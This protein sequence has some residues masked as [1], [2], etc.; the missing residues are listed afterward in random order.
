MKDSFTNMREGGA[1]VVSGISLSERASIEAAVGEILASSPF[2]TTLQCQKLLQYVVTHTLAGEDD[3][4]RERV[5]GHEVF[6]RPAAYEPGED[7]VVRIRA[8]DVRKR[9]AIYYQ[10]L[11]TPPA[12]RIDIPSGS[13]RAVFTFTDPLQPK[14]LTVETSVSETA[15]DAEAAKAETVSATTLSA[16]NAEPS[17]LS[18]AGA[19]LAPE[20]MTAPQP[21]VLAQILPSGS[22]IPWLRFGLGASC[23]LL[24]AVAFAVYILAP[25]RDQRAIVAMWGPF[26]A[27]KTPVLLSIGSNAVYRVSEPVSDAYSEAHNLQGSGMEFFPDF[28]PQQTL[29]STGLQPSFASF[30]AEGDVSAVAEVVA[31]LTGLHQKTQERFPNNISFAEV[32]TNPTVLIGGFNNPMSL[33][34]TRNL[35]FTMANRKRIEDHQKPGHDWVLS[36]PSDARETQDYAVVTRLIPKNGEAPVLEVAGLGQYGTLAATNFV[37]DPEAIRSLDRIAGH[38]WAKHNL[39]LVLRIKVI[40]YRPA[41]TEVVA[42][43]IW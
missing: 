29:A 30:V 9:L 27:S 16:R 23:I 28:S 26:V 2:R 22:R 11:R 19:M 6:G 17:A 37:C 21:V 18:V 31:A 20:T 24:M 36:A 40:D 41:A 3:M 43:T 34:F 15:T 42:S 35:R 32:Q 39:Q 4:L 1:I 10:S 33:E 12:T 14:N 8:A 13:Y 38:D 7:P 25:G 5:V